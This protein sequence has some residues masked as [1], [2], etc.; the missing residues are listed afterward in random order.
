MNWVFISQKTTFFIA[1]AVKTY[2]LIYFNYVC[3]NLDY[4]YDRIKWWKPEA[5]QSDMRTAAHSVLN[6]D[7][8]TNDGG[9]F[10]SVK[11]G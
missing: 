10:R 6:L 11:A 3:L 4:F 5:K 8:R 9:R 1:T 7:R 2:N